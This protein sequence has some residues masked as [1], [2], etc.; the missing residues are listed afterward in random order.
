MTGV[1]IYVKKRNGRLEPLIMD[2][3]NKCAERACEGL[4]DVSASEVVLDAHV[5]LYNKIPTNDIDKALI[6]S[7]RSKIEKEP[8]Y[9]F[10]A[11]RLLAN[12]I[13]KEVFGE[14]VDHHGFELQ[15]RKAFI[16]N[17]KKLV[18]ADRVDPRLL[19][20]DLKRLADALIID[21][22][23]RFKY[24]GLQTLYDRYFIHINGNRMETPQ[25]FWMRVAMGLSL[26]EPDR[27]AAAIEFYNAVSNFQ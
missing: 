11:A 10:V 18:R 22:D 6:F 8:N 13:Y 14:G 19:D 15:Y 12:T 24:L 17:L 20:F 16:V 25:A 2:K 23:M 27:E 5:Q 7:A 1:T 4:S 26:N 21:N 3:V 9:A